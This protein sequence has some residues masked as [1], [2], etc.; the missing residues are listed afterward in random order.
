ML[1]E[2]PQQFQMLGKQ[3]KQCCCSV[4]ERIHINLY[5]VPL[6]H[7]DL[8]LRKLLKGSD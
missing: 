8:L 7:Q 5:S 1:Q 4:S 3:Q 6:T 2:I